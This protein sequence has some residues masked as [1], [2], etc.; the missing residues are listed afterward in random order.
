MNGNWLFSWGKRGDSFRNTFI[1]SPSE[2]V[3]LYMTELT[4]LLIC[5]MN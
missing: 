4:T 1:L 3:I 2:G 5:G